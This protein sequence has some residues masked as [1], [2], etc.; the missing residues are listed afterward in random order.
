MK[1]I[2]GQREWV[3]AV[4]THSPIKFESDA[5][6]KE[7]MISKHR[8]TFADPQLDLLST[9]NSKPL[10][11][12]FDSCPLCGGF[13]D[14]C[15]TVEDQQETGKPDQLPRHIGNHLKT[16]AM[17]S[18][19]PNEKDVDRTDA[20]SDSEESGTIGDL[21]NE[22]HSDAG[23][24]NFPDPPQTA[25]IDK[26]S[27]QVIGE[28]VSNLILED[29]GGGKHLMDSAWLSSSPSS[30][31]TSSRED[32]WGF[33]KHT[34]FVYQGLTSQLRDPILQEFIE[35][36][37]NIELSDTA[38]SSVERSDTPKPAPSAEVKADPNKGENSKSF[39]GSSRQRAATGL[40]RIL[41]NIRRPR[42]KDSDS[43]ETQLGSAHSNHPILPVSPISIR[44]PPGDQ[45]SV[46]PPG[47]KISP[48]EIREL[49]ELIRKRYAL[50]IEI[51]SKRSCRP[52]D[53]HLVE[54]MMRRSDLALLKIKAIVHMWDTPEV[55]KSQ[56]DWNR[57]RDIRQ[58]LEMENGQ[59]LW[60][61]NPPWDDHD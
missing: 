11:R 26:E 30:K 55:W 45:P 58:R 3:C 7:H 2:H 31:H 10:R 39:L 60:S 19:L 4:K 38:S 46:F 16:L 32:E 59:R 18:L 47:H 21:G 52:R 28:E 51:W 41:G 9:T 25:S 15:A 49:N 5:L 1:G 17:L 36:A 48:I 37:K 13:P 23:I 24:P 50:D 42:P 12:P 53:R 27:F 40:K 43:V 14:D 6:Y 61:D 22:E 34:S 57:L 44:L 20:V 54:E 56:A 35:R 8:E 29:L 33:S